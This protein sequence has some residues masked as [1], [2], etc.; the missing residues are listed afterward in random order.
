VSGSAMGTEFGR[1]LELLTEV[2]GAAGA[3]LSD[4]RGYAIDYVRRADNLSDL[5][6]QLLG[7][8]I[9]QP[10]ERLAT[11]LAPRGL[12]A[13]VVVLESPA[14]ALF[15]AHLEGAYA[16]ALLLAQPANFA[17]AMQRFEEGF[18]DMARLL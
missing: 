5:D 8:Q 18:R 4:D 11:G 6:V 13:P 16:M 7:A 10:L 12:R 1:V 3:V 9:G 14:H 15:V 2:P 17:L